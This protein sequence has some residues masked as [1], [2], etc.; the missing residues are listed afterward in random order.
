MA[1]T[2]VESCKLQFPSSHQHLESIMAAPLYTTASGQLWHAGKILVVTVG[3]PARGKT[4]LS[5]ALERYLLWLGVKTSVQSLGD[6]RRK[7]LGSAEN[8][9]KDYFSHGERN[10][11]TEAL[12]KRVLDGFD[13]QVLKFFQ[14][15]GQVVIY[16]A[17]NG[18]QR[19]RKVVREK[20]NG[21]AHVM[22]LG[23]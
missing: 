9:P 10:P 14:E 5:H 1:E 21:I 13:D 8:L 17:N 18:T 16:D 2:E 3:L 7:V 19:R 15:G 11:E 6:Y 4:H 23:E 12:R 20:F 22:F